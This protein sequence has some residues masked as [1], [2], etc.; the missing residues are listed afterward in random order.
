MKNY[1]LSVILILFGAFAAAGQGTT[2]NYQGNLTNGGSPANGSFDF[3]F[4]LFDALSGGGQIGSTQ[5]VKRVPVTNGGFSV[6][7]NFGPQVPRTD[8]YL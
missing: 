6:S 5:A 4:L 2:F 3:E 1:I 8:R 7:L